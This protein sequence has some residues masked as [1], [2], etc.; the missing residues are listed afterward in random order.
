MTSDRSQLAAAKSGFKNPKAHIIL[1]NVLS[2]APL[3]PASAGGDQPL[4]DAMRWI[5]FAL[6]TAEEKG[7]TQSNINEMRC[8]SKSQPF[9]MVGNHQWVPKDV[10][11]FLK[12]S[13]TYS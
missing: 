6:F 4:S 7:M 8:C 9:G 5:V 12:I 11:L 10:P 3:A 13:R 2:K 1:D